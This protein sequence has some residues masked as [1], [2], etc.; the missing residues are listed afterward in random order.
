MVAPRSI[1]FEFLVDCSFVYESAHSFASPVTVS[2]EEPF[3]A[4]FITVTKTG[5]SQQQQQ[6]GSSGQGSGA[7]SED[8]VWPGNFLPQDSDPSTRVMLT[9]GDHF[10]SGVGS[11]PER[12]QFRDVE[13]EWLAPDQD[14]GPLFFRYSSRS[15]SVRYAEVTSSQPSRGVVLPLNSYHVLYS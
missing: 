9:C 15:R 11:G 6:Q 13:V 5:N 12:G 1:C 8:V 3:E 14:V 4:Y 10:N 2:S 7:G